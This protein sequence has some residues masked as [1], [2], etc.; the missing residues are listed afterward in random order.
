MSV[1]SFG[2]L[3]LHLKQHL[4]KNEKISCPINGCSKSFTVYS[5]FTSHLS[6]KHHG[7]CNPSVISSNVSQEGID[8]ASISEAP[9][10]DLLDEGNVND[11][12]MDCEDFEFDNDEIEK[13][14]LESLA[15]F[16]LKLEGKYLLPASTIQ[17]I[18]SEFEE[19]HEMSQNV[20]LKRVCDK[21][22]LHSVTPEVIDLVTKE[23]LSNDLFANCNNGPLQTKA[24][25]ASFFRKYFPYCEPVEVFLCYN[26]KQKRNTY[27]YIPI[28]NSVASLYSHYSSHFQFFNECCL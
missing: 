19:Y 14:F 15:L 23:I 21:L 8:L 5:T 6:R 24:R 3:K 18:V 27:Q 17:V 7:V 1:E 26:T 13:R 28:L 11:Y 9:R 10:N 4:K 22:A 20:M 16:Y 2:S 25:R 12:V